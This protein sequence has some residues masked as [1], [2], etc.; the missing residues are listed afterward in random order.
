MKALTVFAAAA[1]LGNGAYAQGYFEFGRIPG[2][3]AEPTVQIDLSAAMLAFVNSAARTTDP[4]AADAMAGIQG[5]RVY[6]YETIEDS[7]AVLDFIDDTSGALER[8]GWER[9]VFVQEAEEKVRIYVKLD[10]AQITGLTVMVFDS[11]GEAVFI[12]VAGQINPTQLGQLMNTVGMDGLLGNL[13]GTD[14]GTS[15]NPAP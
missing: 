11:G 14:T 2:I 6:V 9:T 1:V 3:S 12:N 15:S 5:V 4:A 13:G 7:Q 10:E 8:D